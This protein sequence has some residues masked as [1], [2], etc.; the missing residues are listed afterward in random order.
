LWGGL[1]KGVKKKL[2]NTTNMKAEG[3]RCKGLG[4]HL[5]SEKKDEKTTTEEMKKV[6]TDT[7]VK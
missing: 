7:D 2:L 5:I 1:K 4:R 3:R 6:L